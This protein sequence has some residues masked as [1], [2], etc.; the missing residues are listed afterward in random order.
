MPIPTYLTDYSPG[1]GALPARSRLAS[2]APSLDLTG[3]WDF[4]LHP[5]ADPGM[6]PHEDDGA[7]PW[8]TIDV[9]AHWVL[10]GD[11][12]YGRPIYTN[13]VY[14]FPVDPPFVPDENPTGDYRR[15]FTLDEP[16]QQAERI[17]LR[18]DG[19]ESTYQVW[20]NGTE[21]GVGKGSRLVHEFDVT[22][23]VRTGENQLAVR[24]HQWS[25]ASYLEDQDQWWLPGIFREVTLLA[26]PTGGVEDVWLQA[27]Y[28][29]TTGTGSL[30][31]ELRA[32]PAAAYP[33]R[34]EI[35]ELGVTARWDR[36]E[37]VAEL[38]AGSVEPWSAEVP[39]RY[40]AVLTAQGEE[41][42][43]QVG[44]R[45]VRIMGE[46][47][48]VNGRQ[49]IF[50]G[51]NRHEI[52][53]ERGR[54][55]DP[56][57]AREDL[58]LMKRHNVNAIRTSH[59]PPH[60]GVLDLADELGFWVIDECDLETH[61]FYR[62][63]WRSHPADA[64]ADDSRWREAHLDRIARTV[65]RDKNHPSIIMWSLGNETGSGRNM[66]AMSAWV[67]RRDPG[68]PVHYEGDYEGEYTDV[69]SRMYPSLE[70]LDAIG[71]ESGQIAY[72]DAAQAE[73]LRRRPFLMCEYIHAMGNGPGAIAEY[74]E[75]IRAYPRIHGGFVWEWR[76]HGLLTHTDDGVP[77]YGY[78]GD[79]GEVVHDGNFVTDGL[80]LSDGTP[81][82]GL[83]EFAAV[84]APVTAHLDPTT[85]S[86]TVVN[87]R[88]TIDTADLVFRWRLEVDGEP[89]GSGTIDVPPVAAGATAEV[90][91]PKE[92]TRAL[93]RLPKKA[94]AGSEIWVT[95][96]AE[97]GAETPWAPA[98]H[99]LATRQCDL[100]T[101]TLAGRSA[102]TVI[103]PAA[104]ATGTA[105]P[106]P[107]ATDVAVGPGTIDLRTG[108]L[109]RLWDLPTAGPTPELWRA[110]TD[111][112]RG[113]GSG[114]YEEAGGAIAERWA[115][116][117]LDR[118]VHRLVS[119]ETGED[120]VV[121]RLRSAPA[122]EAFGIETT[123][124]YLAGEVDD[125]G[126]SDE[127]ILR[128]DVAAV[129]RF[130]G[131]WPRVGVRFD[132][133]P[134]LETARWFGPGPDE[135]YPDSAAAAAV[136]VHE[137]AVDDLGVQYAKPQETGHRPDVR[138]L[139]LTGP[140]GAGLHVLSYPEPGR[141]GF[142][143]SRHTAQELGRAGHAHELPP[144]E[145]VYLYLDAGQHGLGTGSCGPGALPQHHLVPGAYGFTVRL[146]PIAAGGR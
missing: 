45:T 131:S 113:G 116:R 129:G 51:V 41:I 35:P 98:G 5:V 79:F 40:E 142:T 33:V 48:E 34:L 62:A 94:Q 21:V 85:G 50:R 102:T 115:A 118:L 75:K 111:N 97:L 96:T 11:G 47:F 143:A 80:I 139:E 133:P 28:D 46:T 8:D 24:V 10:R 18:F 101:S 52:E 71:G 13:V 17:L 90:P 37:D 100:S 29:H 20:L 121:T 54:V 26:R 53:A 16:W 83:L 9:P 134:E 7:A 112:D 110:P 49:V 146:R 95:L 88:H 30:A 4:R 109:T 36:P 103:G 65:E 1:R 140:G 84:V 31:V 125:I 89:A 107:T 144:S 137:R 99:V 104:P 119:V 135:A 132:L 74:D 61:G 6:L 42:R 67:H 76:D 64:P 69:Y 66:A 14:P 32:D 25:D 3:T 22:D 56:A 128:V 86:V 43:L 122:T 92:L 87:D 126:D 57:H 59:Y 15:T 82:P 91:A 138:W 44:F 73:R 70:A 136:A 127:L 141:P 78:G 72:C 60:P 81:S 38:D 130:E 117:G 2:D 77:Y 93:T 39:R 68:R 106:L 55:F 23:H 12:R 63:G 27:G 145:H 108:R 19:V 123:L 114:M 120:R 58:A 124:T 105:A